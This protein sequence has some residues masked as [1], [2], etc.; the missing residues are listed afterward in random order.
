MGITVTTILLIT[1]TAI[2]QPARFVQLLDLHFKSESQHSP[3]AQSELN[4][5]DSPMQL[6]E[7]LPSEQQLPKLQGLPLEHDWPAQ[8]EIHSDNSIKMIYFF[9]SVIFFNERLE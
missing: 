5:Q 3:E 8:L 9:V 4:V 2:I 1:I 6:N 7:H